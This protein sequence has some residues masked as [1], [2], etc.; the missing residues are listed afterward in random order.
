MIIIPSV[1][2]KAEILTLRAYKII[3]L[4]KEKNGPDNTSYEGAKIRART[5]KNVKIY[6]FSWVKNK[7]RR[8]FFLDYETSQKIMRAFEIIE[9]L[10]AGEMQLLPVNAK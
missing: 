1:R 5:G 9:K 7:V 10:D 4:T 3:E 8:E 6:L 2:E